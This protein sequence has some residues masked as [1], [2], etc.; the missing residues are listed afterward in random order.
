MARKKKDDGEKRPVVS[1]FAPRIICGEEIEPFCIPTSE[2]MVS[3]MIAAATN[4]IWWAM[5]EALADGKTKDATLCGHM[6]IDIVGRELDDEKKQE[7][8]EIVDEI[9]DR[10]KEQSGDI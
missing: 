7:A 9:F 3:H 4:L 10:Y 8:R 2:N 5:H 6:L 1:V